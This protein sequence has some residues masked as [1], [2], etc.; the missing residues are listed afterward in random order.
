MINFFKSFGKKQKTL[1]K[2]RKEFDNIVELNN[3]RIDFIEKY[4]E[5]DSE[6]TRTQK[7][8]LVNNLAMLGKTA[9][10]EGGF[11]NDEDNLKDGIY[12]NI[13]G[14][15]PSVLITETEFVSCNL[16]S[17]DK[18]YKTYMSRID[19]GIFYRKYLDVFDLASKFLEINSSN[20][21]RKA[22]DRLHNLAEKKMAK[23]IIKFSEFFKGNEDLI[24]DF[25]FSGLKGEDDHWH[26]IHQMKQRLNIASALRPYINNPDILK[27]GVK[28]VVYIYAPRIG[29]DTSK[30]LER[31]NNKNTDFVIKYSTV[32][33]RGGFIS[34]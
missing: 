19:E 24:K 5:D 14:T 22:K 28:E 18:I 9:D 34:D 27:I 4:G 11:E 23:E 25:I 33:G 31:I 1:N 32:R 8:I 17:K 26:N 3:K 10:I 20:L 6:V 7:E 29:L 15:K 30:L 21:N 12:F 13:Q 16:K 2:I